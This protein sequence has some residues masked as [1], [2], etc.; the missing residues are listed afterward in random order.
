[1]KNGFLLF[2][3][4]MLSYV[5]QGQYHYNRP[6]AENDGIITKNLKDVYSDTSGIYQ[7]FNQLRGGD[8]KIHSILLLKQNALILEEYFGD[9]NRSSLHDL[10]STTKSISAILL[11]IAIDK[12]FIQDVNDPIWRYLKKSSLKDD[13]PQAKKE[14]TIRQ[15]ITMSSGLDCNDW[16]KKSKGQEDRVYRKKDW[17]SYFLNLPLINTPGTV[18][19]YCTMGQVLT[20]KIIEEATNMPIADFADLYLFEP[21]GI[22]EVKWGHTSSSKEVISAAKRLYMRPRDMAKIGMLILNKGEWNNKQLVSESWL[23]ESTKAQTQ[24]SGINYGYLWWQ[25]PFESEDNVYNAT[26]ATGNGGQYIVIVPELEMIAVFTGG[27]YNSQEDK[28]PFAIVKNLFIPL[29]RN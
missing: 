12:G 19:T 20:V 2:S 18:S 4:I 22:K 21:M 23:E 17:L 5:V 13:L 16:D 7:L 26:V 24:I 15:L 11:G 1:M 10:R 29:Y 3:L 28:L 9:N 25:I 8:H 27:A 6:I 14:I